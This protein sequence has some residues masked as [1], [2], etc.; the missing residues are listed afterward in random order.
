MFGDVGGDSSRNGGGTQAEGLV[1]GVPQIDCLLLH[2][3]SLLISPIFREDT[4]RLIVS[5]NNWQINVSTGTNQGKFRQMGNFNGEGI[6]VGIPPNDLS[7]LPFTT[8]GIVKNKT[9][10]V[11]IGAGGSWSASY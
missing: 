11:F 1:I 9:Q 2:A 4:F 10:V 3:T 6:V 5:H 8:G 7:R